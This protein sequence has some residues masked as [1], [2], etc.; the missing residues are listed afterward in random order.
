MLKLS[1]LNIKQIT[2]STTFMK[3]IMNHKALDTII[4]KTL[5]YQ[6]EISTNHKT[7]LQS[8]SKKET[9]IEMLI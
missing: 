7:L 3:K 2:T 9:I 1:N 5:K 6:E 4:N 8:D